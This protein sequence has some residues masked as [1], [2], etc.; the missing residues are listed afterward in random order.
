MAAS[1]DRPRRPR[2]RRTPA[3]GLIAPLALAA[4]I[5]LLAPGLGGDALADGIA[6][7]AQCDRAIDDGP[8]RWSD[9]IQQQRRALDEHPIAEAALHFH[10][11]RIAER[12]TAQG[13]RGADALRDAHQRLVAEALRLNR[14]S[15]HR[16]CA[17]AGADCTKLAQRFDGSV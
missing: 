6:R 13:V 17:A 3:P 9:C 2:G 14:L 4:A 12:A 11:W 15:L 1:A 5:A 7:A 10:A 16:L 8:A